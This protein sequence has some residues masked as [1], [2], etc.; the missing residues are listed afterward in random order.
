MRSHQSHA[1]AVGRRSPHAAPGAITLALL[2]G[3][4]PSSQATELA[5]ND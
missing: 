2:A 1:R 5:N 4:V 3:F